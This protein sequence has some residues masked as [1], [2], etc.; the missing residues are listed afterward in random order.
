MLPQCRRKES[1]GYRENELPLPP[2]TRTD[3]RVGYVEA[4]T[5]GNVH[6]AK[7]HIS[8]DL[9]LF[10]SSRSHREHTPA[11]KSMIGKPLIFA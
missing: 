6:V 11:A 1:G 7:A 4:N 3:G 8:S 10:A 5:H 9:E 2:S